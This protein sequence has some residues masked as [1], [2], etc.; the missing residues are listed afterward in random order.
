MGEKTCGRFAVIIAG[1]KAD[2]V[3][4]SRGK[5]TSPETS[6]SSRRIMQ[7]LFAPRSESGETFHGAATFMLN[8]EIRRG[9]VVIGRSDVSSVL[10][11][12][13]NH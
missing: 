12:A 9:K 4:W 7:W 13:T 10:V 1:P 11:A 2:R 6:I 3:I 8:A 5:N